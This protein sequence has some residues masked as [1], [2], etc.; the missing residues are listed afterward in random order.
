[1]NKG[2]C[3]AAGLL[4]MAAFACTQAT[5]ASNYTVGSG[6]I[7]TPAAADTYFC[8][9]PSGCT[10]SGTRQLWASNYPH[11]LTTLATAL[12]NNVDLIYEY[13]RNNVEVVPIYGL[14]KGAL[15]AT[16]DRSGTAFDQAQLMVELLRASGY[17]ASYVAGTITLSGA[18]AYSWFGVSEASALAAMLADGGIPAS[19]SPASGAVSS[20]TLSHIW[21][22][23]TINGTSYEF[24]PSYKPHTFVAGIDIAAASGFNETS[25]ISGAQ[26][27]M[28]SGTQSGRLDSDV[29]QTIA[30][31]YVSRVN[32]ASVKSSLAAYA[33]N[34]TSYLR[35]NGYAT[36]QID[37]IIGRQDIQPAAGVVRQATLPN[38]SVQHVWSGNIPDV[39]RTR[40]TLEMMNAPTIHLSQDLFADEVYGR[41]VAYYPYV[42][43]M[44]WLNDSAQ[45]FVDGLAVGSVYVGTNTAVSQAGIR[46]HTIRMTIDHPYASGSG[47][48]MDRVVVKSADFISPVIIAIGFGETGE[49]LQAKLSS[50]QIQD[51]LLPESSYWRCG[52]GGECENPERPDQ[53]SGE[54]ALVQ[55][56][57]GWLA[58][59]TRMANMQARI[60]NSVHQ[61]HDTLGIS[62]RR[63]SLVATN[64]NGYCGNC[65][66]AGDAAMLLDVDTAVSVNSKVGS[67]AD[68]RAVAR[69]LSLAAHTLEAS[70]WEE[71]TNSATPASVAHRF[72][73]GVNNDANLR[74]FLLKPQGNSVDLFPRG[75]I[76][77][78]YA[79]LYSPTSRYTDTGFKVIAAEN[80]FLGPGRA[81]NADPCS[82]T[83]EVVK[84]ERGGA[85]QAFSPDGISI[86][87][88]VT[89]STGRAFQGGSA[90]SPPNFAEAYSPDK[91]QELLRDQFKDRSQEFGVDLR[92]GEFSY[93]AP[94]DISVG[95]GDFPYRLSFNR[96]FRSG[97]AHSPGMGRGWTHNFD[98]R[99]A[100][101][102]NVAEA[103]G[104]S[105]T[106]AAASTLVALYATQQIYATD[107]GTDTGMLARW[108][109]APFVHDWWAEKIRFNV[110]THTQGGSSKVFVRLSDGTFNPPGG[111]DAKDG[112][113]F[114]KLTQSGTVTGYGLK[115]NHENVSY[116]LTSPAKEVQ[117]FAYWKRRNRDF[118]ILPYNVGQHFGWHIT[119]WTFPAGVSLTFG[120]VP[121]DDSTFVDDHLAYVQSSLGRRINLKFT[122]SSAWDVC[123]LQSVDDNVGHTAAFDCTNWTMT[124]PA[125][126]VERYVYG[127]ENC[128]VFGDHSA[129][130]RCS[131]FLTEIFGPADSTS[132]Q[133][134][135]GY[136]KVGD[137]R[138]YSDAVAVKTPASRNS[139]TFNIAGTRGERVDPA[140]QRYTVYYDRYGRA[141]QF[142]NELGYAVSA[143]YDGLGRVVKRTSPDGI[144]SEF[145]YDH[146][147]NT[148][149]VRQTAKLTSPATS[150]AS[151]TVNASYDPSCGKIKTVTDAKGA[152]TTW[153]YN[154]ASCVVDY[155]QQ[156]L[157]KD[158][159]TNTDAVPT[160]SYTYTT[161]GAIDNL[162]DPTGVVT[163]YDYDAAGNRTL[164]QVDA[165]AVN[166]RMSYGYDAVGNI[167]TVTTGR[168]NSTTFT[169][170]AAR[171]VTRITGPAATCSITENGWVGG[172]VQKV[173]NARICNP[174]F[175]TDADWQVWNKSYT[176]TG[177]PDID[178]D[179]DGGTIDVDYDPLD[180]P[181][182]QRQSIGG[183]MPT[184]VTRTE[185]DAAGQPLRVYNAWGTTDQIT[186]STQTYDVE[187]RVL[188]LKDANQNETNYS[189]DGYGRLSR[190]TFPDGSY[191]T[192]AYDNND[193]IYQKRSR[194]GYTIGTSFDALN[195]EVGRSVVDNPN[196]PGSYSRSY[197][198]NYDLASRKWSVTTGS[199]GLNH[200]YDTA[201]RLIRVIDTSLNTLGSSIGNVEYGYDDS[202]NR[203]AVTFYSSQGAMT[204]NYEFDAGERL[205][206]VTQSGSV[207]ATYNYDPMSRLKTLTYLDATSV[208]YE[209]EADDDLL[210]ITHAYSGGSLGMG[211]THNGAHQ[212][213]TFTVSNPNY[214]MKQPS[215][216]LAYVPNN[217]NQ[218]TDVGTA[219]FGYDP[220][221]NLI[222]DGV[223]SYRYDEENFLRQAVSSSTTVDYSYDALG[224][225]RAKTVNGV[226]TYF[227][228][229]GVNELAEL[230][231]TGSRL[232][233]YVTGR[234]TDDHVAMRDEVA[235]S[236]WHFFHTNHQGSSLFTT[237]AAAAGAIAQTFRYDAYGKEY[238]TD[239]A[240][241][242]PFRFAGRYLDAE[243]GLYYNRAR[244]YSASLGRFLQVDPIGNKDDFNLYA[245]VGNDPLNGTDPTGEDCVDPGKGPCE[246]VTVTALRLPPPNVA[247]AAVIVGTSQA[248]ATATA[249]TLAG[250]FATG[251][252]V[253][254]PFIPS[255]TA[256]DDTCDQ[257]CHAMLNKAPKDA[258]DPNGAKA[259]GK[260]GEAEG[261]EDPKTGEEW[262]KGSDGRGGWKDSK[263]RVWQPTGPPG[264][265]SRA[266][267]GSHWDRQNGDGTHTNVYPG[268]HTR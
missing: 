166:A 199:L 193:N 12:S 73:W 238:S 34:L 170:D 120:Y 44:G 89:D 177:Q 240:T 150:P 42:T 97:E 81:C 153:N 47:A 256:S 111:Y 35:T 104:K 122:P 58:S 189:Y 156:P 82:S 144:L 20:V 114:W 3:F 254:G 215:P 154:S 261:F 10:A 21:V 211:Y 76:P 214:L 230:N 178:T 176:P 157:V 51:K 62:T 136:D 185:Y 223:W 108:V 133:L 165:N 11:E 43:G 231:S 158:G 252:A 149:M 16:I 222:S 99:I 210:S 260:P 160:T 25:F 38:S 26:S 41:R 213:K 54:T 239:S 22:R 172:R 19:V 124:S 169:Y 72:G 197:V 203:N 244:Y 130:P 234:S 245:Y 183:G 221:G 145:A 224:R 132:P 110:A 192:Y 107:P 258:K 233:V 100:P 206:R 135:L 264:P 205:W 15:G 70:Q 63:T 7:V 60:R 142:I 147:G 57:A 85:F 163:N 50:E 87:N 103:L 198:T 37:D 128:G 209:Y 71:R 243:T 6:S 195:R 17:S 105:S 138:T 262:V 259:P 86:S 207:L 220:N 121:V 8:A 179:P 143:Q 219:S 116:T 13:V 79:S 36:K 208:A 65:W 268:G 48:Y 45:L 101:S 129:R 141:I 40:L 255:S 265:G 31:P 249:G 257:L 162:T 5:L 126:D 39:Y 267:G 84:L 32:A 184:R 229:D 30:V 106:L 113:S 137:V 112:S 140:G 181:E 80:E 94:D 4:G 164:V 59:H 28:T 1:M 109:I 66:A 201:G 90:G 151:L 52:A 248:A 49:E 118:F 159:K 253:L 226:V 88:V 191:E 200:R 241:G 235:G 134:R 152:V 78:Y 251:I 217:L 119:N 69:S 225:R 196:Y 24:D 98:I 131:P 202:G 146:R 74:F 55:A 236:G 148:T 237:S 139:Y 227:I 212:L 174:N 187:G 14:Q 180:R 75:P 242:N 46:L 175:T 228:N 182:Y 188:T 194:S 92:T 23:V 61:H 83:D 167:T 18:Q 95:L 123:H 67:A 171:R 93:T 68:R 2:I 266:H 186:Y 161:F 250:F 115:W 216:A 232:R 263:G 246:T 33:D 77:Y 247:G 155:V 173:R 117:T 96:T 91:S 125:G 204:I 53:P 56:Y 190:Q 64:P 9:Q 27:G 29:N 218:Y 127:T 102:T 168:S